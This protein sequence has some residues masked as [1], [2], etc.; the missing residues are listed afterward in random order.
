MTCT[1]C[2]LKDCCYWRGK[3]NIVD[4]EMKQVSTKNVDTCGVREPERSHVCGKLLIRVNTNLR[5]KCGL[6]FLM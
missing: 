5:S 6:I 3:V 1:D 2:L 4:C